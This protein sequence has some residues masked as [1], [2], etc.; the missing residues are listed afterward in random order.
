LALSLGCTRKELLNRLD[1]DELIGW[2]AFYRVE[3][4]GPIAHNKNSAVLT[5]TMAN[6]FRDSKTQAVV[7]VDVALGDITEKPIVVQSADTIKSVL[8]GLVNSTKEK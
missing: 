2:E 6:T 8:M 5:A 3:P 4:F 7:P 1:A